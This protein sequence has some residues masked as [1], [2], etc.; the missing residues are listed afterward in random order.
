MIITPYRHADVRYSYNT[1]HSSR[2]VA[3]A[4]TGSILL[5]H[6]KFISKEL[7]LVTFCI[8]KGL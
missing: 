2:G 8:E 3:I 4:Y 7:M 5:R 6:R 1:V